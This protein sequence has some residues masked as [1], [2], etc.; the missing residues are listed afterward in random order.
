MK[1]VKTTWSSTTRTKD[2]DVN[3][4][5]FPWICLY[6]FFKTEIVPCFSVLSLAFVTLLFLVKKYSHIINCKH[7]VIFYQIY[8]HNLSKSILIVV[9]ILLLGFFFFKHCCECN[10]S[11]AF[12]QSHSLNNMVKRWKVEP[13]YIPTNS[14]RVSIFMHADMEEWAFQIYHGLKNH[15]QAAHCCE[16]QH[17]F[18]EHW[19]YARCCIRYCDRDEWTTSQKPGKGGIQGLGF[20]SGRTV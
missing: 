20:K 13:V 4:S 10:N 6:A 15:Q 19:H 2:L 18:N 16:V 9:P 5:I 8:Q 14:V 1:R 7:Y 17:T 3:P 12:M 11:N